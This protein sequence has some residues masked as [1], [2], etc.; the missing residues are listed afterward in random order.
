MLE[1][2]AGLTRAP[3]SVS[4]GRHLNAA[5]VVLRLCTGLPASGDSTKEID[6]LT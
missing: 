3:L 2:N 5:R 4:E 6:P 1:A